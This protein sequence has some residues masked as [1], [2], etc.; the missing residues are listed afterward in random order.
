MWPLLLLSCFCPPAVAAEVPLNAGPYVPTPQT[1]VDQMLSMANVGSNDFVIDLGSGDGRLVRQAAK[2]FGARGF[3][4]DIDADLVRLSNAEAAKDGVGT[5]ALFYQKDLFDTDIREASVLTLYLLPV[6]VQK[7]RSK[8]LTELKPGARVVS[9]DYY[10]EDWRPDNQV[11]FDVPEKVDITGTPQTTVYL[12]IV[13]ASVAG[14]WQVR[15][16]GREPLEIVLKQEFQHVSGTA[17]IDGR[18]AR[19]RYASLRGD[20]LSF[21]VAVAG[22]GNDA[23]HQFAGRVNGDKVEGAVDLAGAAK[24]V[25]FTGQRSV[26]P[27]QPVTK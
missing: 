23:F 4:V 6:A 21:G 3:G 19:L 15:I 9:H 10:M 13:P 2:R 27:G 1:I 16:G 12:W 25:R 14:R 17:T 11:T 22:K 8:I 7:L 24:G 5:R 20:E 26:A 18:T